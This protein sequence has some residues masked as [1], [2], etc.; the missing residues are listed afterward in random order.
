MRGPQPAPKKPWDWVGLVVRSTRDLSTQLA[1][2]PAGTL[3][4]CSYSRSGLTIHSA[5]CSCCGVSVTISKVPI[6]D[7]EAVFMPSCELPGYPSK[8]WGGHI[9]SVWEEWNWVQEQ[10]HEHRAVE[11]ARL[12]NH[13]C[14]DCGC[15]MQPGMED[16]K[17]CLGCREANRIVNRW[18]EM[19]GGS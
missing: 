13:Q 3:F 7:V 5:A 4:V 11:E 19:T 10:L 16:E 14:A 12:K 18:K 1:T 2:V 17:I 15:G 9:E 6:T 8:L